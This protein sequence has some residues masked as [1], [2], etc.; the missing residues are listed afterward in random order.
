LRS[1]GL[2]EL[3]GV[4]NMKLCKGLLQNHLIY[5]ATILAAAMS[6]EESENFNFAFI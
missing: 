2:V 5:I 4:F 6:I 3:L 1:L